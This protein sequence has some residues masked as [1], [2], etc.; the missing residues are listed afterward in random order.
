MESKKKVFWP[1]IMLIDDMRKI[2]CNFNI[3]LTIL[4][5]QPIHKLEITKQTL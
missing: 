5:I 3:Y 2:N 4:I 1:Y